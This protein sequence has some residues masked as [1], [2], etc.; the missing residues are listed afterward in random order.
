LDALENG[1][2]AG[3]AL[4]VL[5]GEPA[6]SAEHPLLAYA[7]EHDN[8]LIVPHIGGNTVESFAKT[9]VFLATRVIEALRGAGDAAPQGRAP[10][11]VP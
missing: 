9:E 11:Q 8:L 5:D 6:L 1:T 4:D 2:I 7:R 3:A 10:L